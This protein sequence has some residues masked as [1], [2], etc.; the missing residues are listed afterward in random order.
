MT[1]IRDYN[2][3]VGG[4]AWI[5]EEDYSALIRIF[6]DG[7]KFEGGWK[8][9]EQQAKKAEAEFKSQGMIV[10]RVY[11]DPDTFADW[12]SRNGVGTGRDG[13]MKFGA[14]FVAKKYGRNQS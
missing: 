4:I 11:I 1:T 5:R 12:C 14:D 13:R 6:E 7:H 9:W 3:R 2:P 10:E 8:E